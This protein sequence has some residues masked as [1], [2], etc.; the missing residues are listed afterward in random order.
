[1]VAALVAPIAAHAEGT[2]SHVGRW[3][4]DEQGRVLIFH[5]GVVDLCGNSNAPFD[6]A[7]DP[8]SLESAGFNS[9]KIGVAWNAIEPEPGV[10]DDVVLGRV[11]EVQQ[12]FWSHGIYATLDICGGGAAWTHIDTGQ[13]SV[14]GGGGL[15][16]DDPTHILSNGIFP[17][18]NQQEQNFLDNIPGPGGVGLQDRFAAMAT[19]FAA[20]FH[21]S[22]GLSGYSLVN[23]PVPGSETQFQGNGPEGN[24]IFEVDQLAPFYRKVFAAFR[25]ADPTTL[26]HYEPNAN[27][28]LGYSPSWIPYLGDPNLV[29]DYHCYVCGPASL[30]SLLPPG[31]TRADEAQV[32]ADRNDAPA[33]MAEQG[34]FTGSG[35]QLDIADAAMHGWNYWAYSSGSRFNTSS[36]DSWA[37]PYPRAIAGTPTGWS[38]DT[39]SKTFTFS[40]DTTQPDGT[41]G[42]ATTDVF[43]PKLVYTNGYAFSVLDGAEVVGTDI[44]D[45]LLHFQAYPGATTVTMTVV[46]LPEPGSVLGLA[47]GAA[48]LAGLRRRLRGVASH[49]TRS[50]KL[51]RRNSLYPATHNSL[52]IC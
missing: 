30:A 32:V 28:N 20:F 27:F 50:P 26:I 41:V 18:F 16:V 2:V 40:Y 8:A 42:T 51:G 19:H 33:F 49:S 29:F 4:T 23:E 22:P 13:Y 12:A 52:G 14:P 1:M 9:I 17:V 25:E 46:P 35:P 45:Q 43:L 3:F 31:S 6:L 38:F 34:F 7:S 47:G 10:Y 36:T 15:R 24:V 5:G 11:L 37:R 39:N 44:D 21:D 48:L